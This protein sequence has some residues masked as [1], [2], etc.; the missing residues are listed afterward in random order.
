[1]Q[2]RDEMAVKLGEKKVRQ[3][4]FINGAYM[5]PVISYTEKAGKVWLSYDADKKK[6]R[7]SLQPKRG[8]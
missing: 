1:M 2:R 5:Y 6:K 3:A 4:W 7:K 8:L